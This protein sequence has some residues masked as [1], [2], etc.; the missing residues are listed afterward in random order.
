MRR[1]ARSKVPQRA[2]ALLLAVVMVMGTVFSGNFMTALAEEDRI[3]LTNMSL[4]QAEVTALPYSSISES[5]IMSIISRDDNTVAFSTGS[6]MGTSSWDGE[7]RYWQIELSTVGYENL[8]LK[9][10]LRSSNTGPADFNLTYSTDG[11]TFTHLL[12]DIE[13]RNSYDDVTT[14]SLPEE[15]SNS[16]KLY[17]RFEKGD[18]A[19]VKNGAPVA[20]GGVSNIFNVSITGT[21]APADGRRRWSP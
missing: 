19:N 16:E 17:L 10:G 1:V 4:L 21:E 2:L 11:V 18:D 12:D 15:A 20:A 13:V 9:A 14:V 7:G 5:G 8:E 3:T 6:N